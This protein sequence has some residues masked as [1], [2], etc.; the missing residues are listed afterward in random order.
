MKRIIALCAAI[1]VMASLSL[2]LKILITGL[3]QLLK[4][5]KTSL[6]YS[7]KDIEQLKDLIERMQSIKTTYTEKDV[8]EL[9]R[10]GAP[11]IRAI[12][13]PIINLFGILES[14][15]QTTSTT[16]S[17]ENQNSGGAS[18]FGSIIY[19]LINPAIRLATGREVINIDGATLYD[20][21]QSGQELQLI[22]VRTPAEWEQIRVPGAINIPMQNVNAALQ[23]GTIKPGIPIVYICQSGLEHI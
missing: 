8:E 19:Q 22:D 20:M 6:L 1:C 7:E 4:I 17:A 13:V 12:L 3:V 5:K 18:P 2:R 23:D 15:L 16:P 21:I 11:A 9:A 14:I 10:A